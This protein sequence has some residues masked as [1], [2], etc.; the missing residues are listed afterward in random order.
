MILK[1]KEAGDSATLDIS[2]CEVVEGQFGEQVKFEGSNGDTIYLPRTSADRQLERLGFGEGEIDY[3]LAIGETLEFSRT[4]ST[5]PGAKPFW[6]INPGGKKGNGKATPK[7]ENKE[8][9]AP[10]EGDAIPAVWT[11]HG[12]A[13]FH[14][15]NEYVPAAKK[16]GVEIDVSALTFQLFKSGID[17]R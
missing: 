6:N 1:L 14:V 12:Q 17:Q 8:T 13:F 11:K 10:P 4:P 5:K 7:P 9:G 2:A 15:L 16:A 3:S